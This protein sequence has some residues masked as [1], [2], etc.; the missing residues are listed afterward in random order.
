M[1]SIAAFRKLRWH[2]VLTGL[3]ALAC[4]AAIKPSPTLAE[5]GWPSQVQAVYRI[6][7]NGFDIGAFEFSSSVGGGG[8]S[9]AGDARLSAL[10]GAFKWQGVTRASGIL[11]GSAPRPAGYSFDYA[12]TGK[13]GSVKMGFTGD[14]VT[15]VTST[16]AP[17]VDPATVTVKDIHLKG[18]LDP[19]SAIMAM[20]K[21]DK[22]NPC[23]RK[24]AIFDGRQ[25]FDLI[26]SYVRQERIAEAQPSGQPD[27]VHVCK[28]R[29]Q[30]IAGHK[31]GA[32]AQTVSQSSEI[33]LSLR[34]IPSANLFV[35]HQIVI[36]TVVGTVRITAQ[37]VRIQTRHEQIALVH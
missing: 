10:L 24:L 34:P 3:A 36:P 33:A 26:L 19:L 11:G 29:Y 8:Y 16:P 30:P 27:I 28:V 14:S 31:A 23:A 37:H 13:A 15:S 17:P 7:F 18:V 2:S 4:A 35:P 20:A 21:G 22:S 32:E 6:E 9:L 5:Q 25:R 1:A 12:G